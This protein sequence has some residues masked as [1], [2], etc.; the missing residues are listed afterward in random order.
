MNSSKKSPPLSIPEPHGGSL[1]NLIVDGE[2]SDLLKE[3]ASD[4]PDVVLNDRQLCDFEML[5]VGAFSPLDGF[6]TRTDYE[7]V[8]DRMRLQS[9]LLW[10]LPVCLDISE[11]QAKSLEAGQSLVIRD[12]EG[13][14]L[15]VQHVEDVWPVDR[16]K[17]RAFIF[18]TAKTKEPSEGRFARS[19]GEFYVGGKLEVISLPLHFALKQIRLTPQE[20]R[21]F[22]A[23]MGWQRV[24]GFQTRHLIHPPQFEVTVGAMREAKANLLLLPISGVSK[25]GNIDFYTR[26]KCYRQVTRHYPPDSF[27]LNLLPFSNH[28]GG[29]REVLLQ[30]IISKNYGCTHN[31]TE[32]ETWEVGGEVS[33]SDEG[34]LK[35]L[36]D[37]VSELAKEIGVKA[38]AMDERVYVPFE[39]RYLP[40]DQVP[41]G[42]Q[43]LSFSGAEIQE[44]VR[45]GRR[46]PAWAVFPEV[47]EALQ[48]AFPPPR[49]QGFTIF[50]TGYSG[51]GKSTVAKILYSR[52]LEIGGRPVTLL[53]GDIVRHNLSSE[54]NFSKEHRDINVRRIGFVSSEITKNRGIAICAPIAPYAGTRREIREAIEAW[55]G[56]IEVHMATPLAVCEKRDRKGMYAKAR[57][58]LIKGFTGVDDPYEVPESPELRIDTTDL[59]PDESVQEILLFLGQK[60]YI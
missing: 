54:L 51:A 30:S 3:I 31:L 37:M 34:D 19:S 46:I 17:E 11:T 58:G 1:V 48:T 22:Y 25:P 5:A 60:G 43:S 15:G 39:D 35:D 16:E 38:L 59:T 53:D 36:K 18:G 13:F 21:A 50:F 2:R 14:L 52:F 6:M 27:L 55:G 28:T 26:V 41:E 42:M 56:F 7:S 24:I 12:P 4:L 9:G 49:K 44:R 20:I 57:A 45:S 32:T 29:I 23:K 47:A 8:M 40:P 33:E 10:P